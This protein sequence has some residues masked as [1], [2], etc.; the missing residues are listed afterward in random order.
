VATVAV[1]N[2]KGGVGKTTLAVNLAWEAAQAGHRTLLWEIDG[3]GDCS[4]LMGSGAQARGTDT[5]TF[6]NG[7]AKPIDR[8]RPT[9]IAGLS[10]LAADADM[11]RTDNFFLGFARQQRLARLLTELED[12]FDVIIFDN[13]PGFSEANKKLLL[14]VNLVIV[15]VIPTPLARRGLAR[16]R[17]FMAR[18]RGCHAPILPVFSMVDRRRTLHIDALATEPDWPVIAMSSEAE[19]MT[20][21]KMPVGL[22]APK[23]GSALAFRDLWRGVEQ[24]LQ[25]MRVLRMACSC[26]QPGGSPLQVAPRGMPLNAGLLRHPEIYPAT[27]LIST[28]T[29][30][31]AS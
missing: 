20:V 9:Q 8:V 23:S 7:S 10:I 24:K 12:H 28:T 11:Q 25:R 6:L 4:W 31:S 13:P 1:F 26:D 16:I 22:F 21:E 15:P 29:S 14:F 2:S 19:K 18:N 5:S 17:D 27:G 3:Q 30:I